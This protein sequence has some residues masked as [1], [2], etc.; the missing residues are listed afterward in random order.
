MVLGLAL[1]F[2]CINQ[3]DVTSNPTKDP[4][5]VTVLTVTDSRSF[6]IN[7][8]DCENESSSE[9]YQVLQGDFNSNAET[10]S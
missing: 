6:T 8:T 1:Y 9:H 4:P 3:N 5:F 10:L 2:K 7:G